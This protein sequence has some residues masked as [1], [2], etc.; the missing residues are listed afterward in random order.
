M[1]DLVERDLVARE[2]DPADRRVIQLLPTE[3]SP[4]AKEAINTVWSG[5]IRTAMTRL[6][7]EQVASIEATSGALQALHTERPT[8]PS[9]R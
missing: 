4:A 5:T 6:S 3:K 8:P 9:D 1:R 7:N 2:R